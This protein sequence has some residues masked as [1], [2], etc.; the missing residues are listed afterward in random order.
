MPTGPRGTSR[1][2]SSGSPPGRAPGG[3]PAGDSGAG[4]RGTRCRLFG[5]KA[6]RK[7]EEATVQVHGPTPSPTLDAYLVSVPE[8]DLDGAPRHDEV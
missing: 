8:G 6:D 1:G 3:A 4:S 2:S 7:W 5:N